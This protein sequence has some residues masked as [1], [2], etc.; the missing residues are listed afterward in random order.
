MAR[1]QRQS[2][3]L[4]LVLVGSTGYRPPLGE[5]HTEFP[6]YVNLK[7][8]ISVLVNNASEE[9]AVLAGSP[10]KKMEAPIIIN[11]A[12][13]PTLQ[14]SNNERD[15][16]LKIAES[17]GIYIDSRWRTPKIRRVM[18]KACPIEAS[19]WQ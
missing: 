1:F 9:E 5:A 13:V 15:M 2:E 4:T 14:G 12:P 10:L 11:D 3:P 6:K 8:G 7:K 17:R 19:E 18:D 16:L